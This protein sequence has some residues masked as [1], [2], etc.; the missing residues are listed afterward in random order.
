MK[1][2]IIHEA[3]KLK[4]LPP[5][6]IFKDAHSVLYTKCIPDRRMDRFFPKILKNQ[7]VIKSL[8]E[9]QELGFLIHLRRIK[10]VALLKNHLTGTVTY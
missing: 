3:N 6:L 4:K 9:I 1:F 8:L 10:R 5:Q 2:L 7:R